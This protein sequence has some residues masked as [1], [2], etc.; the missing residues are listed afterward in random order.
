MQPLAYEFHAI[1]SIESLDTFVCECAWRSQA[2]P[3]AKC[4]DLLD[5]GPEFAVSIAMRTTF[6]YTVQAC[7]FMHR[8]IFTPRNFIGSAAHRQKLKE[9]PGG[10]G[11]YM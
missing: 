6:A 7:W 4:R 5:F 8:I 2:R 10:P 11:L 1:Q 3:N 9:I